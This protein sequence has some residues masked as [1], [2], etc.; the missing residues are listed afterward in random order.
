VTTAPTG[1][2]RREATADLVEVLL[3]AAAHCERVEFDGMVALERAALAAE[4]RVLVGELLGFR[5][6]SHE[7]AVFRDRA[8]L[9]VGTALDWDRIDEA[10]RTVVGDVDAYATT[11]AANLDVIRAQ[12]T[13]VPERLADLVLADFT[14]SEVLRGLG[15]LYLRR[16]DLGASPNATADYRKAYAA[17]QSCRILEMAFVSTRGESA[18]TSYQRARAILGAVKTTGMLVPFTADLERKQNLLHLA[19]SLFN[20]AVSL[21]V[22]QFHTEAKRCQSEAARLLRLLE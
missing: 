13:V 6:V 1:H 18:T 22:G 14:D 2:I 21:T 16:A 4:A 20:R 12:E 17:F 7:V 8:D 3:T 19:I 11:L 5:D 10:F 9:E 15:S